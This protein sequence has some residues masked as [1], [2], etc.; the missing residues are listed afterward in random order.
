MFL[1]SGLDPMN[2]SQNNYYDRKLIN[3]LHDTIKCTHDISDTELTFLDVT[4]YKGNRFQ[5][6]NILDIW[7]HIKPTNNNFKYMQAHITLLLY[8]DITGKRLT[9]YEDLHV[10]VW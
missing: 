10:S 1:S 4:L 5:S 7:T 2:N 8:F 9:L 6:Q 3:K